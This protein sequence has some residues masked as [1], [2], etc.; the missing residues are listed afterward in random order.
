MSKR[1]NMIQLNGTKPGTIV[2]SNGMP[3]QVAKTDYKKVLGQVALNSYKEGFFGALEALEKSF[4]AAKD[5]GYDSLNF[6]DALKLIE[7]MRK[8]AVIEITKAEQ[9]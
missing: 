8:M 2:G 9:A 3:V 6:D 5:K 1:K 4:Q 7:E